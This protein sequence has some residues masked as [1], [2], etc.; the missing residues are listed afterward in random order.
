MSIHKNPET[1]EI[2]TQIQYLKRIGRYGSTGDPQWNRETKRQDCCGA[3]RSY[4][5]KKDCPLCIDEKI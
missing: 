4:Y 1:G 2:E 5:H 3:T